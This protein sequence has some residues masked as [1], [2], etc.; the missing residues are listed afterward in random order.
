MASGSFEFTPSGALQGKIYWSS[1]SNGSSAN[2]SNVTAI[3]YARR[4]DSYTTWAQ[5]WSGY[6]KV[7]SAQVNVNFSSTVYVSSDWVEMARVTTTI[8]HNNDGTGSASVSG[9][10]TGPS[11][12]SLEGKTSSGSQTVTLDRIPRYTS[13]TSFL[14]GKRNETSFTINW[15]TADTVDYVYYSTNNGSSWTGYDVTD[16]T[17]GSF[18]ITGLSPNTTY[19]CKLR[20]RRKDSQLTTDSSTVSQ[21]TYKAP[22]Q[23]VSSK[24]ETSI[25]MSWSCDTTANYIWYSKDNGA[26][27]TAVGS[28]SATSGTYTIS[29]LTA[30]TQYAIKTRVRRSSINTTYDTTVLNND[31]SKT[32][33]YPYLVSSSN[34]IIGNVIPIKLYNPLHR[35][36]NIT[37]LG[38]DDSVICTASRNIEGNTEIHSNQ[39]EIDSQYAS[40]PNSQTGSYK[41]RIVCNEVS[42]DTTVNGST[43]SVIGTEIPTFSNF[44]YRDS[45]TNVTSVT[46]NDQV[47]VKGLSTVQVTVSSANKMVANNS[48]DPSYY[49]ATMSNLS[50]NGN[51]STSDV[52]INLGTINDS[53]TQ[54]LTVEA[55]DTRG[56]NK[57]VYKD[58][59]VYDYVKPVVNATLTR[60]NNFEAETTL[61]VNGTYTKLAINNVNKN[62]ITSVK[63]RY[64]ETGGSWSSLTNITT[65][66][67]N[68]NF[69]CTDV[70]L[71][72]NNTKSFEFEI[73]ATD[74]LQQTTTISSSVDVGQAIFFIST[75]NRTA[76]IR[77]NEVLT[78]NYTGDTVQTGN[79]TINGNTTIT[80]NTTINGT[81]K[82]DGGIDFKNHNNASI[83]WKEYGYGDQFKIVPSFDGADDSNLL[84][85]QGTVGGAG[86]EPT[87]FTD[88][89]TVSGKSGNVNTTGYI[90]TGKCVKIP[91]NGGAGYG[92]TNSDGASIIRDYNNSNVTVD[93][94]GGTLYLGFQNTTGMNFFNGKATMSNAG[95]LNAVGG[96]Q[97]NGTNV[98]ASGTGYI[99]YYDG[100]MVC[101]GGKTGTTTY[102]DYWSFVKRSPEGTSAIQVTLP[103]SF[104]N[105]SYYVI[106][107]PIYGKNS[108]ICDV[109]NSN[110]KAK[111][112]FRVMC[113]K[114]PN[115]T[116]NNYG[117]YYVAVGKW[118]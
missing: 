92:L 68:G 5:D 109:D 78:N 18:N 72:L 117:F 107:T 44:T 13:I 116:G 23:S 111:N 1:T 20:V 43:Y 8:A 118:K 19:N 50:A 70:V 64:R 35:T 54:R 108:I 91:K 17:S 15:A 80:G 9:S 58:V 25:T 51:Y 37:I 86:T 113:F 49:K 14:V 85:I 105:T 93:A 90:S 60:L 66:N 38:N 88:L 75:N 71:S 21:T 40:I 57:P 98:V 48:A 76:Y 32:Y 61:K 11:G 110:N 106:L 100:T 69:T 16:G 34:F 67:N 27:W 7:G 73:Q 52:V 102:S 36:L 42:R 62:S 30:D 104:V 112:S 74:S 56:L 103:Q 10:V 53:G 95:L 29:N 81:A 83:V 4:T 97:V 3:L 65:T 39:A 94:T 33:A 41:V 59:T 46:D 89:M 79:A 31:S 63:Y 26:N 114:A 115:D 2:S 28:V 84:K 77:D 12:T 96:L 82:V 99:K 45:N 101:Y 24:T 47:M 87:T 55:Y 22:T 6:V